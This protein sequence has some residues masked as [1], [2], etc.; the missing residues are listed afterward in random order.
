[1]KISIRIAILI[2]GLI[3]LSSSIDLSNLA[4]YSSQ[5]VPNYIAQDNTPVSNPITD[6]GAALGRVLF[7]DKQLSANYTIACASCHHQQFAFSDTSDRSVG[8]NSGLTGRHAMRLVNARFSE[9]EKFFW[10]ERASSVEDQSTQPIQDH[11][12][13]GFSGATGDPDLDSLIR[14]MESLDYYPELF[15]RAFGDSQITEDRMQRALAQFIRSIQSFDSKFDLGLAQVAAVN[16]NFPNF[17]TEENQ[18]KLLFLDPPNR[19]GAGCAGCHRPPEFDIDPN[20]GNN[21]IVGNLSDPNSID[22]TNTR[23]PSIRDLVN[24]QGDL[25]GALMHDASIKSL[26]DV[27]EHYNQITIVAGNTGI[28]PR[29][30]PQGQAQN[31]NLTAIEKQALESFLMTLTGSDMYTNEKWSDPFE[32]D[33][34]LNLIDATSIKDLRKNESFV[35]VYPN[36]ASSELNVRIDADIVELQIFNLNNELVLRTTDSKFSVEQL[37][38]GMY[39]LKVQTAKQ[40]HLEKFMITH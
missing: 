34:S 16:Q 29:L 32:A 18:G 38:T 13:M 35:Q 5:T 21:G 7:Y 25:N 26:A 36:P 3:A 24:P 11:V 6:I 39:W 40:W 28:D 30:T 20:S 9:E 23:A 15:E 14:K 31:L 19:G 1:M 33:G 17:S 10:D 22:I 37:P 8:L 4:N 2:C 27:I 12:E